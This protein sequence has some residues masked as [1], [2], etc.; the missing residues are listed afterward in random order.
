MARRR[1]VE[2]ADDGRLIMPAYLVEFTGS[3][4]RDYVDFLGGRRQ[5]FTEHGVKVRQLA[6]GQPHPARLTRSARTARHQR[7]RPGSPAGRRSSHR[8]RASSMKTDVARYRLLE[9]L[10]EMFHTPGSRWGG[11]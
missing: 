7:P 3:N 8:C 5:W 4:A 6:Q 9:A 11:R 2:P 1:P 10:A